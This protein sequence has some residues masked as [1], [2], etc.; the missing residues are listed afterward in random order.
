MQAPVSSDRKPEV[1]VFF[2]LDGTLLDGH[3]Y[4]FAAAA[5]A[6]ALLRT[7]HIPLVPCTSK[8]R[9]EVEVLR[10]RLGNRHPFIVENGGAVYVPRGTFA[11]DFAC[12]RQTAEYQV[13][14]LGTPY[15]DLV[16][17]L[18]QLRQRS[19]V[20]LRGFSDMSVAEVARHTGLGRAD[21]ARAKEREFDEPFV[22]PEGADS[23][24]V[25]AA[26]ERPISRGDRFFH[27]TSSDKG[28]AVAA[29]LAL[30]RQARPGLVSIGLGGAGNDRTLLA[31]VDVPILV[32]SRDGGYDGAVALPELR[33]AAG[34]GPEGWNAALLAQL[35]KRGT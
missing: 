7:R 10:R 4:S 1:V 22:L 15:G 3:D 23:E 2:D 31:A 8:T 33:F 24:R 5:P 17:E 19:G 18:K 35:A 21:A 13:L 14:E 29:L 32:E 26:S 27:L 25:L 28:R 11:F 9:A 34:V 30:Y 12:Q 6:R 16:A 20:A